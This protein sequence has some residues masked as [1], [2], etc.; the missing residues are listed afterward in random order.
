M[1][2]E[3]C[4]AKRSYS[5]LR[6]PGRPGFCVD[7]MAS[8]SRNIKRSHGSMG[9]GAGYPRIREKAGS[10]IYFLHHTYKHWVELKD[11]LLLPTNDA[12]AVLLM[13]KFNSCKLDVPV[14]TK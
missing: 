7:P 12:L 1:A 14:C 3:P 6:G 13:E 10:P 5:C 9:K 2:S 11:H 8:E 4:N